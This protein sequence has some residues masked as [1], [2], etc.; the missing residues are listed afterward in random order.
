MTNQQ[1]LWR[2]TSEIGDWFS[3]LGGSNRY[4]GMCESEIFLYIGSRILD[5]HIGTNYVSEYVSP[6]FL[7]AGSQPVKKIDSLLLELTGTS[8]QI[9][10]LLSEYVAHYDKKLCIRNEQSYY[11]LKFIDQFR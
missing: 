7:E 3:F 6:K 1:I 11:W 8:D 5:I 4:M 9:K 2:A 10:E